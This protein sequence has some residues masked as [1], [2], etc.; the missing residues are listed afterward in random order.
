MPDL[1][2]VVESEQILTLLNQH[3]TAPITDLAPVEGGLVSRTFSFRAGEQEYI[4]RFNK[5]NMLACN[6]PKEAYLYQ[7]LASSPIPF[8]P[9]MHTGRLGDLYFA[10]SRKVPGKML[11]Q[12]S[13]QEVEQLLPQVIEILDAIHRVDVSDTQ[14]YGTFDYQ[15]VGLASSWRGSLSSVG[16]E[17]DERDYYGKWY[18]LFED[19]F[20]EHDLFNE[21]Y[22]HM[23]HLFDFCPSERY[24]V[25]GGYN[26]RNI[27]AQDGK[28]TAVLDW[29]DAKYGD[30][31]YDI[32]GLD[33][34]CPWLHLCERF[35]RYYL[36]R[37]VDVPFF[38]ERLLC[39]QC[40]TTLDAM[41]FYASTGKEDSYQWV[42]QVILQKLSASSN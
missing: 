22:Q 41:R 26:F 3:F 25:H 18:H 15:G 32:A 2:A 31:V 8:P 17:E 24:L 6:L 19:T 4:V 12:H 23:Q 20:L 38:E 37:Q 21:I 27:L 30:F 40:Y 28:I 10:I 1:R 29:V 13:V 36:E 39:Y 16:K 11:Q 34:W 14:G 5:D 9:I 7:R 42:R 33:Y 35:Q